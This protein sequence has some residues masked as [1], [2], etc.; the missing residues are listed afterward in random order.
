MKPVMSQTHHRNLPT[1]D[2]LGQFLGSL[3]LNPIKLAVN[4]MNPKLKLPVPFDR[5]K[6][7]PKRVIEAPESQLRTL[8]RPHRTADLPTVNSFRLPIRKLYLNLKACV[9]PYYL[10]NRRLQGWDGDGTMHLT[11]DGSMGGD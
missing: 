1:S 10:R 2:G 6:K 7:N 9:N 4:P 8:Q 5:V 11:V 3:L